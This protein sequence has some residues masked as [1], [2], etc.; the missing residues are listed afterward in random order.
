MEYVIKPYQLPTPLQSEGDIGERKAGIQKYQLVKNK[1][2]CYNTTLKASAG[3][4]VKAYASRTADPAFDSH[5]PCRDF[6][7]SR[8]T[9]DLK[10]GRWLPCQYSLLGLAGPVSVYYD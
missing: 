3:L 8:H 7:E 4:V 1:R 10:L 9:S 6:S 2:L 5:L